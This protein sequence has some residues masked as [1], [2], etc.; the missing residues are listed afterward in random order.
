MKSKLYKFFLRCT[1]F[2][3]NIIVLTEWLNYSVFNSEVVIEGYS[4]QSL[5]RSQNNS[6]F[7]NGGGILIAT[8]NFITS[9][10]LYENNFHF[11]N[12]I[13]ALFFKHNEVHIHSIMI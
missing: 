7:S 10:I 13:N 6:I 1:I 8:K 2:A 5:D 3:Y 11:F 4:L 9:E 12:S